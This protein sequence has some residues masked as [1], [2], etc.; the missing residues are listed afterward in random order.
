MLIIPWFQLNLSAS[1]F[2]LLVKITFSKIPRFVNANDAIKT[3]CFY[4]LH[5]NKHYFCGSTTQLNSTTKQQK[6]SIQQ[7][8]FFL[9]Y[10]L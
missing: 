8:Q 9:L 1:I 7:T 2:V 6:I 3:K 5:F 4:T 10:N